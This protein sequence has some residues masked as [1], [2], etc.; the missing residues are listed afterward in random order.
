MT[1]IGKTSP[2]AVGALLF[3][4][5]SSSKSK[6]DVLSPPM[7]QALNALSNMRVS[8][9]ATADTVTADGGAENS[10]DKSFGDTDEGKAII[11]GI[12]SRGP[13][14]NGPGNGGVGYGSGP[15]A[16]GVGTSNGPG[17]GGVGSS[18]GAG[19]GGVATGVVGGAAA[20]LAFAV[21]DFLGAFCTSL[22]KCDTGKIDLQC[23]F[24]I[25]E[26]LTFVNELLV[27]SQTPVTVPP[28]AVAGLK[29]VSNALRMSD[30]LLAVGAA[31]TFENNVRACGLPS[32]AFE[33]SSGSDTTPSTD[34]NAPDGAVVQPQP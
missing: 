14:G 1:K 15:G 18:I 19:G 21:C 32:N 25:N 27:K 33:S 9:N 34:V 7:Q 28:A 10:S 16:G 12:G 13:T 30:C 11:G 2:F 6:D 29:C 5:C 22:S 3:L 24:P 20:D 17:G 23:N 31:K 26:C 4:A 8:V